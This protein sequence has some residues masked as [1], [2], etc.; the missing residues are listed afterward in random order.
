V[1]GASGLA[2]M[3]RPNNFRMTGNTTSARGSY[4]TKPE[5]MAMASGCAVEEPC[6]QPAAE[7]GEYRSAP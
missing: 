5:I 4:T 3:S 1:A 7:K 2:F 6:P